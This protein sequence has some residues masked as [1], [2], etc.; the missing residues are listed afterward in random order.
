MTT[1]KYF[2]NKFQEENQTDENASVNN[3]DGIR[4]NNVKI[5]IFSQKRHSLIWNDTM[6]KIDVSVIASKEKCDIPI[7]TNN[8]SL[9]KAN[10]L[11]NI[12]EIPVTTSEFKTK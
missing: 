11:N 10:S 12:T 9:E 6:H 2:N 5:N 8:S 4:S 7:S 3:S 1:F